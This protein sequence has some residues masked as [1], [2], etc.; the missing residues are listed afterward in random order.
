[1]PAISTLA[2][3]GLAAAGAVGGVASAVG[4]DT[5]VET[6]QTPFEKRFEL[7]R[8]GGLERQGFG[9]AQ[10]GLTG[11]EGLVGA[12][13]GQQDVSAALTAQRGF[14]G[15][16]GGLAETGLLPTGQDISR[17]AGLAGQLLRPEQ[18][19]LQQAF[20]RQE[21][22]AGRSAAALGRGV[23]DPILQAKLRT[24]Q[25]EQQERLG[26]RQ[27]S[28]STQL[29]MMQPEQR[30]ALSRERA[31]VLGGL[32]TQAMQNRSFLTQLGQG[33][34]EAERSFRERTATQTGFNTQ[35]FQQTSTNALGAIGGGISGGLAGL[36]AGASLA[37]NIPS[38]FGG[39]GGGGFT[40]GGT[41]PLGPAGATTATASPFAGGQVFGSPGFGG[42]P[43]SSSGQIMGL[44]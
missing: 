7:E 17:T 31:G 32:G 12:G 6:V 19:A 5:S 3:G 37:S 23:G 4:Q 21:I 16:L 34:G 10:Q 22:Q 39:G 36:G 11:L 33:I 35:A 40:G 38:L 27:T 25:M 13:P 1:M 26:A 30:L 41:V 20:G 44:A 8:A 28:L 9:V 29:A 42:V 15:Q 2:L 18:V 43:F 24:S 14:A